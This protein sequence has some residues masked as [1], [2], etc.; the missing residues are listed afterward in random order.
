M[1]PTIWCPPKSSTAEILHSKP[2]LKMTSLKKN[3]YDTENSN[4]YTFTVSVYI[5]LN[6]ER[7][8]KYILSP[9]NLRKFS[10]FYEHTSMNTQI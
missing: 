2:D 9:E 5:Y 4:A 7:I 10:M 1:G 8:C 3:V 6:E